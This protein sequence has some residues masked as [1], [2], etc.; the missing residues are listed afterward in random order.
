LRALFINAFYEFDEFCMQP[1]WGKWEKW[2][3][4]GEMGSGPKA[5]FPAYLSSV[6]QMNE[7]LLPHSRGFGCAGM[8]TAE[9]YLSYANEI[10]M[11]YNVRGGREKVR[12]NA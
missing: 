7:S 11:H 2:G 10:K 6:R 5:G 9:H 12:T 4:V 3:G 1:T 8:A